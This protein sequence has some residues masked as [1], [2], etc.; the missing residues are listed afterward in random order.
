MILLMSS[1]TNAFECGDARLDVGS[2]PFA[3]IPVYDQAKWEKEDP[4]IC[5]AVAASELIVAQQAVCQLIPP[6]LL[7]AV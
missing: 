4:D 7:E 5:Y 6:S 1:I 3:K 2:Q